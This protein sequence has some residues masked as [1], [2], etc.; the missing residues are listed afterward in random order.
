MAGLANCWKVAHTL[1]GTGE[2]IYHTLFGLT[3][4]LWAIL[5]SGYAAK[6]IFCRVEARAEAGHPIGC[7]FIGLVIPPLLTRGG[8]RDYAAAMSRCFGVMPPRP[9]FG[10]S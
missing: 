8:S 1:W 2:I 10:R 7:C 5:L 6:W 3:A 4:V 9:I